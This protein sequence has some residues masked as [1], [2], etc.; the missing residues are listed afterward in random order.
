MDLVRL[1]ARVA[2]AGVLAAW[3]GLVAGCATG[4]TGQNSGG[5][6]LAADP[7]DVAAAANARRVSDWQQLFDALSGLA[8]S[9]GA[10]G[11]TKDSASSGI[12]MP[13]DCFFEGE[14]TTLAEKAKPV[15]AAIAR[16]LKQMGERDFWI[17]VR[18]GRDKPD[19]GKLTSARAGAVVSALV[20]QGVAPQRLAAVVGFGNSEV[21]SYEGSRPPAP[22]SAIV[23][24][25][26]APTSDEMPMRGRR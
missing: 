4:Q 21:E 10:I 13:V 9:C 6:A 7:R 14:E 1:S 24:I 22:G 5:S 15:I 8:G 11:K 3:L 25:I 12:V 20:A 18:P 17:D 19:A 16:E 2:V 23:E 26:V